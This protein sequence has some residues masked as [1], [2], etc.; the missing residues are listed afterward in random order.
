MA[1]SYTKYKPF[2]LG[3]NYSEIQ[4]NIVEYVSPFM[5]FARTLNWNSKLTCYTWIFSY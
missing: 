1:V 5:K 4:T 3:H 2:V